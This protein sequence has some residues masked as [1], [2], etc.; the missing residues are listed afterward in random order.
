MAVHIYIIGM[1]TVNEC[2]V[3]DQIIVNIIFSISEKLYK[4]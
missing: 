3:S 1:K 2:S 4:V